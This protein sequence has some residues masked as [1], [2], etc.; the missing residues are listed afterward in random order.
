MTDSRPPLSADAHWLHSLLQ[1]LPDPVWLKNPD[2]VY[3]YCNRAFEQLF[4]AEA[5]AIVGRRDRDFVDAELADFFRARDLLAVHLNTALS[6]E[7]WVTFPHNGHRALLHVIKTPLH[8]GSA[9]VGVLGIGRDITRLHQVT[10][11]LA[12][13]ERTLRYVMQATGEG[14]WDWDTRSGMLLHNSRWS[15]ITGIARDQEQ[16]PLADFVAQVHE[17]D[18]L[19][20]NSLIARCLRGEAPYYSEH[21]IYRSDGRIIWVQDRGN[22]VEWDEHGLPTRM[23]GSISDITVRKQAE[24]AL[25]ASEA[26]FRAIF[27]NVD[28]LAIQGY[29]PDGTVLYWNRASSRLYGYDA[30]EAIGRSLYELIIPPPAREA[31]RQEVHWMF[32][33]QQGAPAAH[34]Q[35]QHKDG[36]LVDVHSS[37][38]VVNTGDRL[39]LFCLDIDLGAQVRAESARQ[40]SEQRYRALFAAS[41]D[42]VLVVCGQQIVDANPAA[43]R[44]FACEVGDLLGLSP[45]MLSPPTQPDGRDA[46]ILI[47]HYLPQTQQQH[48]LQ[49]EWRFRRPDGSLFDADLQLAAVILGGISHVLVSCRDVTQ[50]KKDTQL[51]WQQA[52]FDQLTGLPNR[53]MLQNRLEQ[54]IARSQRDGLQLALLLLD[55]DHFKEVNDTLGHRAGDELLQLAAQRL[56]TCVRH[57]DTVARLGGDEFTVI[58]STLEHAQQ[59]G[60]MAERILQALG[61]PY[62]LGDDIAYLSASIGITI[63]PDDSS[64]L[65]TLLKNA[66]QAMYAAKGQ[67]RNRSCFFTPSMQL[68]AQTRV[69]L[70]KDL[71]QA[72]A[73]GQFRLHYQ[74]ILALHSGRIAGAEALLRWQHPQ[75]GWISPAEFIPLAEDSGLIVEL[76]SWVFAEVCRQLQQWRQ[77]R[78]QLHISV[79]VSPIQFFADNANLLQWPALLAE[80]GLPGD[81]VVLEITERLL[82]DNRDQVSTQLHALRQCGIRVSLD[83][84]GTGYS[85]LSYLKKFAIDYLKI[86]QSFVRHLE[87]DGSDRALCEAIIA[88]AHRLDMRVV[89]EGIELAAHRDWLCTAGCDFGQGFLFARALPAAE[90]EALLQQSQPF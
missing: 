79:N 49:C 75:R 80:H 54:E 40:E 11:R 66:D 78:P 57:I 4:G 55:L 69:R 22:V 39:M 50:K 73:S 68:A 88:M 9:L 83:D 77:L 45:C 85:S 42:G 76:G 52:N 7:E 62:H 28:A 74:P 29:A 58:V 12:Q 35:L 8:N 25:R 60:E 72:L 43:A 33:Q 31:V 34:L 82:L 56:Q 59:A 65:E 6:N 3:L 46:A 14:V 53:H 41:A 5:S 27:E 38:T 26:R 2:G 81:S 18:Q 36:H 15:E 64:E 19:A 51:I 70:G 89:A 24:Q 20:V 21:R 63:C 87:T 90:F 67:G 48:L 61:A 17:D 23:V 44:L 47:E 10:E 84:F 16:H 32:A 71:R 37:H 13:Q 1:H 30:Q 86:D